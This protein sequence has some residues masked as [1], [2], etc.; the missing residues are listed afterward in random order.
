MK[1]AAFDGRFNVLC[2]LTL[3]KIA[4]FSLFLCLNTCTVEQNFFSNILNTTF[5]LQSPQHFNNLPAF[6]IFG[7]WFR[8]RLISQGSLH[9]SFNSFRTAS[10]QTFQSPSLSGLLSYYYPP[11]LPPSLSPALRP[12]LRFIGSPCFV[13]ASESVDVVVGCFIVVVS[14]SFTLFF[15]HFSGG[16]CRLNFVF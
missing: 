16:G 13:V 2:V 8:V 6:H 12:A 11:A 15:L 7:A 10:C 4:F 3:I 5:H 1:F 9:S 14:V